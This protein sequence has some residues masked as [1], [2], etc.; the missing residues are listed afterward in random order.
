MLPV[1]HQIQTDS[2]ITSETTKHGNK[3]KKRKIKCSISV[4]YNCHRLNI[5]IIHLE[6][7][8]KLGYEDFMAGS[9]HRKAVTWQVSTLGPSKDF[10]I[11]LIKW[12]VAITTHS[13]KFKM[14]HIIHS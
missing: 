13:S 3:V 4:K 7:D 11:S 9:I 1:Y 12:K 8:G 2:R 6:M 14:Y 5:H 10:I